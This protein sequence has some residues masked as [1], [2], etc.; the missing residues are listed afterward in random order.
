VHERNP[1]GHGRPDDLHPG[2]LAD[3]ALERA[4]LF[5]CDGSRLPEAA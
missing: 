2:P 3:H 1:G 4:H 5:V